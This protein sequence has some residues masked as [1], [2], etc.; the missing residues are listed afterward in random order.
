MNVRYLAGTGSVY[1]STD[2]CTHHM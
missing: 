2:Y 1:S